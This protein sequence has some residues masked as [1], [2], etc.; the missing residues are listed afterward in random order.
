MHD[1]GT[2]AVAHIFP[3]ASRERKDTKRASC[4]R[5]TIEELCVTREMVVEV[6]GCCV[7]EIRL[8]TFAKED[9]KGFVVQA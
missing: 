7:N 4:G 2:Q 8:C 9:S 6:P 3:Q 5:E 1:E